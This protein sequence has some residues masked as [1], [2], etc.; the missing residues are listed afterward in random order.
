MN[1]HLPI[2]SF[3]AP[4]FL[5]DR[6]R[7]LPALLVLL[8]LITGHTLMAKEEGRPP[9]RDIQV[10]EGMHYEVRSYRDGLTA[11]ANQL[12]FFVPE[13]S[14]AQKELALPVIIFL[15]G[16]GWRNG[17]KDQCF[18]LGIQAAELGFVGVTV[19]YRLVGEAPFPACI[20]DVMQA[21][22]YV[23][24]ECDDLPIDPERIGIQ[25]FSAGGHLALLAALAADHPDFDSGA[26]PGVSAKVTCAFTASAPTDF[27][28]RI[29]T[30]KHLRFLTEEQNRDPDFIRLVSPVSH[31]HAG[32]VPIWMLQGA[33]DPIVKPF[34]AIT[35]QD[36]SSEA[37]VQNLEVR[38]HP[39]GKHGVFFK[40]GTTFRPLMFDFFNTHLK[41][42]DSAR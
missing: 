30:K 17:D 11:R 24:S 36:L 1:S 40:E 14:L 22:R 2:L 27:V 37:G 26:F 21:I 6:F 3:R 4:L 41:N 29:Q 38:I 25:G 18:R 35:F 23:K 7:Y 12:A 16:G 32:Q 20:Q 33:A 5:I 19:S 28:Q 15:H 9:A 39:D 31:I 42:R 13:N 10:P 8:S 34:H